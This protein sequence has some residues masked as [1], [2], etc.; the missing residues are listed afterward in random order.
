[1]LDRDQT[2]IHELGNKEA[3]DQWTE[4]ASK[5]RESMHHLNTI[6]LASGKVLNERCFATDLA[7]EAPAVVNIDATFEV[8]NP[9]AAEL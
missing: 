8:S 3:G 9:A 7:A 4:L 2:Q 6:L 1:M 5:I